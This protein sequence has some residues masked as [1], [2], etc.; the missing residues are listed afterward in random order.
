MGREKIFTCDNHRCYKFF[1]YCLRFFNLVEELAWN[2]SQFLHLEM[3]S[4][5]HLIKFLFLGN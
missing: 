5:Y 4:Y 1:E 2:L 3:S